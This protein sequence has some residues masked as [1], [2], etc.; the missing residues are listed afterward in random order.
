MNLAQEE[1]A[2]L[3]EA[4]RQLRDAADAKKCWG[5]G[6]LHDTLT[7][8]ERAFPAERRLPMLGEVVSDARKR[9]VERRYDCLGC[10]VCYPAL[11]TNAVNAAFGEDTV[12][13]DPCPTEAPEERQGWPPLAGSY[14]VLRYQA[15]VAVCTLTDEDLSEALAGRSPEELAIVGTLQTENLGIERLILNLLGNPNVRFLIV[16]GADSRKAI[17]HLPGQSLVALGCF[18]VDERGRIVN[19]KGKRPRL[20]NVSSEA[21]EHFRA[22]IEVVDMIDQGG[23]EEVLQAAKR[24]AASDPGP[25]P[26]FAEARVIVPE[27]GY[28]PDRMTPDPCGY[29]VVYVD[30]VRN[31]ILLEHYSKDGL[32]DHSIEGQYAAE[33]YTPAI[34]RG[35]LTRLDHAAY[36][37]RELAR[38]E[39]ALHNNTPYVQ[40]AAAER[41]AAK[42]A[43]TCNT[44]CSPNCG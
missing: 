8:V 18:G 25:A 24:C 31:R 37:G 30:R 42:L 36:L 39:D 9:L 44:S 27:Q 32:L 19:A 5:C 15:P 26:V 38:A 40:D 1:H 13:S 12:A 6:C 21:I 2:A 4:T 11:A 43:T 35:L 28:I 10:D 3:E 41:A 29:L 33:V 16:C 22:T 23:V 34:E 14:T 7:A 20:R 17:G